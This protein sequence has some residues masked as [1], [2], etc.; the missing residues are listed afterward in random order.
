[1]S[2]PP[3]DG[4]ALDYTLQMLSG[5]R[6]PVARLA[7]TG[8]L[9][10]SDKVEATGAA[11]SEKRG[12]RQEGRPWVNGQGLPLI[13]NTLH[14]DL[15]AVIQAR[16]D[17]EKLFG[18]AGVVNL[19]AYALQVALACIAG[20]AVAMMKQSMRVENDPAAHKEFM[21]HL[22]KLANFLEGVEEGRREGKR[23]GNGDP[24]SDAA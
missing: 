19:S 8:G 5:A 12:E 3:L 11:W 16:L 22:A 10:L 15:D 4:A 20:Q 21:E 7:L 24:A 13:V 14:Q 18:A 17:Q 1:M 9:G 6:Y 2:H 23:G